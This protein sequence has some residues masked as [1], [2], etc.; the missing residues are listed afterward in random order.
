MKT[1]TFKGTITSAYGKDL[2]K[3][4][5][6]KPIAFSGSFE[7][8]ESYAE[9]SA[10]PKEMPTEQE[11]VDF[12]NAS[13]KATARTQA[14]TKALDE[15]GISKPKANDPQV[16]HANMVKNLVLNG[17]KEEKAIELVNGLLGYNG[18]GFVLDENGQPTDVQA[19]PAAE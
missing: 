17:K 3:D 4:L 8:F 16:I 5:G 2:Q 7:A 18:Q 10:S 19:T 11:I 9:L 15:A 6:R 1:E 12:V 14:T 13:R